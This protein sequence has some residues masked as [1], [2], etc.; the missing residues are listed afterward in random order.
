MHSVFLCVDVFNKHWGKSLCA[1]SKYN[2]Q[3]ETTI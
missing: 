1:K 2:M 3:P